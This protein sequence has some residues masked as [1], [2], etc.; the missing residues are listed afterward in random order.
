MRCRGDDPSV[1][2]RPESLPLSENVKEVNKKIKGIGNTLSDA[3]V[4]KYHVRKRVESIFST[5]RLRLYAGVASFYESWIG[6]MKP[7]VTAVLSCVAVLFV[8]GCSLV[9]W[10]TFAA[11]ERP[12][13]LIGRFIFQRA[14]HHE[15]PS[16]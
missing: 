4:K 13:R 9:L 6:I 8:V 5:E 2:S 15:M 11:D 14:H 1:D 16:N 3:E 7:K 10:Y 12:P